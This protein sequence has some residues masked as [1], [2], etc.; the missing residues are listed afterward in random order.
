MA[1]SNASA[2]PDRFRASHLV[3]LFEPL[4]EET[5]V[6]SVVEQEKNPTHPF[7]SPWSASSSS[8]LRM[9][10]SNSLT[11]SGLI[12]TPRAPWVRLAC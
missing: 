12:S 10:P 4:S 11:T 7:A 5:T 2:A 8:R 6:L 9:S 3:V 1:K